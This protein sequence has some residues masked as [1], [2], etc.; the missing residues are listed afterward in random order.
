MDLYFVVQHPNFGALS[1]GPR[2]RR[3]RR[4]CDRRYAGVCV[5]RTARPDCVYVYYQH[6]ARWRRRRRRTLGERAAHALSLSPTLPRPRV[7]SPSPDA[8]R[9]LVPPPPLSY[10]FGNRR[11]LSRFALLLSPAQAR[12]AR[13]RTERFAPAVKV[14]GPL[15]DNSERPLS[16][17]PPSTRLTHPPVA[18]ASFVGG[19]SRA[20]GR[21]FAT[22]AAAAPRPLSSTESDH[23]CGS[24]RVCV[25]GGHRLT[26][27]CC[28]SC[29]CH[30]QPRRWWEEK[31]FFFFF[32]SLSTLLCVHTFAMYPLVFCTSAT[33]TV[34]KF[35]FIQ[36][37]FALLIVLKYVNNHRSW[38]GY[39]K[40][41]KAYEKGVQPSRH[42]VMYTP[43]T[44][45]YHWYLYHDVT[46]LIF[47]FELCAC[48][49]NFVSKVVHFNLWFGCWTMTYTKI[50]ETLSGLYWNLICFRSGRVKF[51]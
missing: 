37:A 50:T 40:T 21:L 35:F 28:S 3:R 29:A 11:A 7:P 16:R 27:M 51:K 38:C 42:P 46:F 19:G 48:T 8:T 31:S 44:T 43:L 22:A 6:H 30:P 1:R 10:R 9:S 41:K 32:L 47:S 24:Q 39:A 20:R 15:F 34:L 18:D 33:T 5:S 26:P 23:H 4:R 17:L 49:L 12:S 25:R 2:R 13:L 14:S 36:F 45:A